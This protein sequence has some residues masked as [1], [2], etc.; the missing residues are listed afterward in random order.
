MKFS[1]I[2]A[3]T[4]ISAGGAFIGGASFVQAAPV[5]GIIQAAP[6]VRTLANGSAETSSVEKAYYYHRRHYYRHYYH[7]YYRHYHY[8]RYYRPYYYHRY[9]RPWNPWSW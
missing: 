5:T 3:V 7:P 4:A 9:Y 6:S 1:C 8:R 2:L